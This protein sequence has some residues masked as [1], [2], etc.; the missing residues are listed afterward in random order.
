MTRYL[1]KGRVAFSFE[2]E[3]DANSEEAADGIVD[4]YSYDE[5]GERAKGMPY[6]EWDLR[7]KPTEGG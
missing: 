5:L 7:P 4:A 1:V 2:F 6:I 3:L